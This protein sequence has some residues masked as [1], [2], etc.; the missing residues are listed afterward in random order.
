MLRVMLEDADY[1]DVAADLM[2]F[3]EEAVVFWREGEEVGR[4]RQARIRSLELQDSRSMTRRIRAARRSHPNAFRPW[5][6]ADE[7]L[8]TDLFHE[9]AGKERMMETLGRQEG[10]IATRLRAL[11]L[12]EEDAKLL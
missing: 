4:H 3:D 2:T 7:Q 12:L 9:G 8:L 6:A 5:T 10:G 1:C 11:G